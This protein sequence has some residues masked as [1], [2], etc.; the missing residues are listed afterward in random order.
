MNSYESGFGGFNYYCAPIWLLL[1]R[2]SQLTS[3]RWQKF[4]RGIWPIGHSHSLQH[5]DAVG[6]LLFPF[7]FHHCSITAGRMPEGLPFHSGCKHGSWGCWGPEIV[8]VLA[9]W[10]PGCESQ[11]YCELWLLQLSEKWGVYSHSRHKPCSCS[12]IN[13]CTPLVLARTT[14][15]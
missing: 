12:S 11:R 3:R 2:T 5:H 15:C 4:F 14:C 7:H 6:Y 10:S 9:S 8:S 13:V 1:M